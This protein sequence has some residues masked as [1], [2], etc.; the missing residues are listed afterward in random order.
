M[1]CGSKRQSFLVNR[2]LSGARPSNFEAGTERIAAP[3]AVFFLNVGQAGLTTV[4][5]ATGRRYR[6]DAPGSRVGVD[7]RDAQSMAMVPSLKRV[8][9]S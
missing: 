9:S 3:A 7:P 2:P 8:H 5:R 6:F 4:G 1:C